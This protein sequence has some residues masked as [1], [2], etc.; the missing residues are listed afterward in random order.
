MEIGRSL[1]RVRRRAVLHFENK[2]FTSEIP[3]YLSLLV[4]C[5]PEQVRNLRDGH[6]MRQILASVSLESL[7]LAKKIRSLPNET[8]VAYRTEAL[9]EFMYDPATDDVTKFMIRELAEML[10]QPQTNS[11][12]GAQ[13]ADACVFAKH[14]ITLRTELSVDIGPTLQDDL[15]RITTHPSAWRSLLSHIVEGEIAESNRYYLVPILLGNVSTGI[16]RSNRNFLSDLAG[17]PDAVSGNILIA[18]YLLGEVPAWEPH[19]EEPSHSDER[20]DSDFPSF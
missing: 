12:T 13:L 18:R 6:P 19:E 20:E 5:L 15:E 7:P 2:G 8:E 14:M 3:H 9:C 11:E 17:D 10:T 1:E 16:D 4:S